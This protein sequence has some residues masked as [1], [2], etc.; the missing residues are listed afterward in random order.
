MI[1]TNEDKMKNRRICIFLTLI[2]LIQAHAV[3][4]DTNVGVGASLTGP[5]AAL[6]ADIPK[7]V[8]LM[9]TSIGG[10]KINC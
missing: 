4:A 3:H 5:G 1:T 2:G 9:R 10:E 7:A 6:G 8:A